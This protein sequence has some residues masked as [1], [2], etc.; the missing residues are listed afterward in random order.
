[1]A[2][3]TLLV[4][5]DKIHGNEPLDEWQLCVLEYCTNKARKVLVA[6][7]TVVTSVLGHLAVMLATIGANNVLFIPTTP[8]TLYNGLLALLIRSEIRCE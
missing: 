8:T 5:A 3:N 4:A 6:L 2:A 1:M 7:S